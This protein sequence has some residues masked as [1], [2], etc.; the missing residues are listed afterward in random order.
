MNSVHDMGGMQ[1]FGP[2]QPEADEPLF[3]AQWEARALAMTVA[4]GACG[5]WNIDLSRSARESL[6]PAVY[7]SSSYYEIWLRGLEQLMLERGLV[8]ADELR[9]GHL[10]ADAGAL[11]PRAARRCRGCGTGRRLPGDPPVRQPC[12]L[13]HRRP[14]ACPQYAPGRPH[15]PAALRARPHR[16]GANVHGT[17]IF[18]DRHVSHPVPPFD[19]TPE[20]LYTVV[21][22]GAELWGPDADPTLQVSVDAWEPYL[23]AAS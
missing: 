5:Q 1:G 3:H 15:A 22:D 8:S 9:S 23:E 10:N 7:L 19:Q 4:M 16:H 11:G 14:R 13:C 2:V 18:P 6:P 20:W 12:A 21:F 17:H